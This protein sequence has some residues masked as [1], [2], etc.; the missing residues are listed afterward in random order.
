MVAHRHVFVGGLHRSG[1]SVLARWLT[2][3]S[4]ISG[5][6]HT[7]VPE[8]EGQHLQDVYPAARQLGGP[9]L[10]GFSDQAHLTDR[11]V[12]SGGEDRVQLMK[13]WGPYWDLGRPVLLEKSPPNLLRMRFLQAIFPKASFVCIVR[14]PL[15]VAIATQK[16]SNT[17][18]TSL[19]GHWLRCHRVLRD[20]ARHVRRLR[21][22]R[23]EDLVSSP[24]TALDSIWR[25]LNL[26][27]EEVHP[28]VTSA[29]NGEYFDRWRAERRADSELEEVFSFERAVKSFGY[30]LRDPWQ[31]LPVRNYLAPLFVGPAISRQRLPRGLR[32]SIEKKLGK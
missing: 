16:W 12:R 30:S 29:L 14:H 27:P 19:V 23:Y 9:G 20:D 21:L 17:S 25:F 10:F 28:E 31:Y 22:V 24:A 1:T 4:A 7:G 18:I 26:K 11:I 13:A 2:R 5:L 3:H 8:D 6:S 32:A 15:A